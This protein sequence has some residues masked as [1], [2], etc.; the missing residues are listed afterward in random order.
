MVSNEVLSMQKQKIKEL[1]EEML[2]DI[3]LIEEIA[4]DYPKLTV[5]VGNIRFMAMKADKISVPQS[6]WNDVF[7]SDELSKRLNPN[8]TIF[9]VFKVI[10]RPW[11]V[12]NQEITLRESLLLPDILPGQYIRLHNFKHSYEVEP[13]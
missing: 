5:S 6:E 12:G 2:S 11:V 4:K 8:D 13:E 1:T 10:S 7:S 9:S 3:P